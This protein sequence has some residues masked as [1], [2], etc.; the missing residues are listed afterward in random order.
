MLHVVTRS[1]TAKAKTM[2]MLARLSRAEI[3]TPPINGARIIATVL[4]DDDLKAQW[5]TD[6]R[7]MSDRMQSMRKMLHQGLIDRQTPGRWDH[8]LT[9]VSIYLSK[10]IMMSTMF[11]NMLKIGMFSMLGIT[12]AQVQTLIEQHHVYLLPSG[13]ISVTGRK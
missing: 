6:L 2:G 11:T 1:E 12:P 10:S 7:H 13:R 9:D 5:L 8:L 4:S 3:T